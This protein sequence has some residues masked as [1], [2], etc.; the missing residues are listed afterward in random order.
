MLSS[1]LGSFLAGFEIM[2]AVEIAVEI[3]V[4]TGRRY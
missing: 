4:R 1:L 3:K 2:G